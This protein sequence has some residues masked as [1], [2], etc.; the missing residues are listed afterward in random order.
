LIEVRAAGAGDVT[1]RPSRRKFRIAE[2]ADVD[3]KG[4]VSTLLDLV[5]NEQ[6]ML[7]LGIERAEDRDLLLRRHRSRLRPGCGDA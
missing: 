5:F 4:V 3:E 1:A 7:A 6:R 2:N